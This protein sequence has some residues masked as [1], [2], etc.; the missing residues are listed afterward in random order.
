MQ[1]Y[2]VEWAIN[3]DADNRIDAV[4]RAVEILRDPESTA[5]IFHVT[6]PDHDPVDIGFGEPIAR[7]S[8]SERDAVVE[9]LR[10]STNVEVLALSD[11]ILAGEHLGTDHA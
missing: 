9:Y 7:S 2:L 4:D 11:C 5:T 3:L 6:G 10:R 1:D 8:V